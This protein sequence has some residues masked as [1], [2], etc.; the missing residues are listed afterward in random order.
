MSLGFA[1]PPNKAVS[2]N[3]DEGKKKGCAIEK[4]KYIPADKQRK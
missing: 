2:F 4:M 3:F 1:Q